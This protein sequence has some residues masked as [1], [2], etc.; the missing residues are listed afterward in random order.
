MTRRIILGAVAILV[1]AGAVRLVLLRRDQ[2]MSQRVVPA[3]AV[4]V[5]VGRAWRDPSYGAAKR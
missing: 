4:G 5:D 2:L 3:A 1:I